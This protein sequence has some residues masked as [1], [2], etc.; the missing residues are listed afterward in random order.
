MVSRVLVV[1]AGGFIGRH[2]VVRMMVEGVPVTCCGR[3]PDRLRHLFPALLVVAGDLVA[4][5]EDDWRGRLAGVDVVVNAAGVIRDGA[6]G[7]MAQVHTAGS[8]R[9]FRACRAAG[10]RRVVH[11]SAIGAD[12]AAVTGFHLS[13]RAADDALLAMAGLDACVIRP[14]LVVGRGGAST[15][16][17]GALA[18]LPMRARLGG[19]AMQPV[20]VDDLSELVL[21]LVTMADPSSP[22]VEAVGP[23]RMSVDTLVGLIGRWLGLPPRPAVSMPQ[24]VLD[25]VAALGDLFGTG[26]VSRDSLRMLRRGNV[27]DAG[28]FAALLGR[29][30]LSVAEALA[31]TPAT[32][33][34]RWQARLHVLRPVLRL[35]L[36]VLWLVTAALSFGLYPVDDSRRLLAE[37][38]LTGTF[39]ELARIAAATLDGVLGAALLLGWRPALVGAVQL[40]AMAAFTVIATALP[41]A[42]WL[43]PFAPLLK[44]LP[45]AAATLVMMALEARSPWTR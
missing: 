41:A 31:R 6:S 29:P 10:V 4:D 36:A 12:E 37:A 38:G 33:A 5:S 13:K 42:Y 23:E 30:P 27:G 39:A 15:V 16:L 28:A 8:E 11:L 34:D 17:F 40:A 7:S 32:Q 45:I 26:A 43:H 19:G 21:R 44:N 3:N 14:S 2:V 20:S 35:S 1:G 9:L 22:R 25:V 18:A 24:S